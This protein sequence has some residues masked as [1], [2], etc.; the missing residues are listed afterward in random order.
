MPFM[1]KDRGWSNSRM[2]EIELIIK[3][4]HTSNLIHLIAYFIDHAEAYQPY[5]MMMSEAASLPVHG[6]Q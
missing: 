1:V 6:E 2:S 3:M 5:T 4:Q